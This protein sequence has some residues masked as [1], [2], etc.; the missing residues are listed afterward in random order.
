[1]HYQGHKIAIDPYYATSLAC[2]SELFANSQEA[3]TVKSQ[4]VDW[5][6]ILNSLGQSTY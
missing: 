6:T 1:M 2:Y 4:A 3:F 5:S